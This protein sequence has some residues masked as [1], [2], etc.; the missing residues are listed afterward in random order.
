MI[1]LT[2]RVMPIPRER[3]GVVVDQYLTSAMGPIFQSAG[4][5]QWLHQVTPDNA[6]KPLFNSWG[7]IFIGSVILFTLPAVAGVTGRRDEPL[8]YV[9]TV[10]FSVLLLF[11]GMI[12]SMGVV[13][14]LAACIWGMPPSVLQDIGETS[15]SPDVVGTSCGDV[16]KSGDAHGTGL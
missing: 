3:D 8:F 5:S 4:N 2:G 1:M 16:E 9:W 12:F 13:V 14:C 11:V 6:T 10:L 7:N 15:V